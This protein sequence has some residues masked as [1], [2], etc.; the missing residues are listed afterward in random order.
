MNWTSTEQIVKDL[1]LVSQH[2]DFN[3][4]KRELRTKIAELHPDKNGGA[5]S[6]QEDEDGYNAVSSAYEFVNLANRQSTALI[7]VTQIPAIIKAVREAQ[8]AP[9]QL[10]VNQLQSECREESRLNTHNHYTFPRISSG[11][12]GTICLALFTFSNSLADHPILGPLVMNS[13]FNITML[14]LACFSGAFFLRTWFRE[15]QEATLTEY[16]MS[17]KARRG[18]F[19][20]I[21]NSMQ[22]VPEDA[23]PRQFSIRNVMDE[24]ERYWG[25]RNYYSP[26]RF[27]FRFFLGNRRPKPSLTEKI[28]HIHLLELE[29]RGAIHRVETPSMDSLYEFDKQLKTNRE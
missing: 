14:I 7:P 15:R 13:F 12:F 18:I 3:E 9:T 28:A 22:G 29:K 25:G 19:D 20:E 17:E 10:Q 26:F 21:L 6:S 24:I 27:S 23:A 4:L 5:F 8:T 11:V 16:Y 2:D 1:G